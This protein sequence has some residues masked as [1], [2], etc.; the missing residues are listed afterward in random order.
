MLI[1]I[2]QLH[3]VAFKRIGEA[4]MF[5]NSVVQHLAC[6]FPDDQKDGGDSERSSQGG[7]NEFE[8]FFNSYFPQKSLYI[9]QNHDFLLAI[10]IRDILNDIQNDLLSI[11]IFKIIICTQFLTMQKTKFFRNKKLKKLLKL[12]G[13]CGGMCSESPLVTTITTDLLV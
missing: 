4:V 5:L 11:S 8:H 7:P 6:C 3:L 13:G 12:C 9:K 2:I 10:S 1:T